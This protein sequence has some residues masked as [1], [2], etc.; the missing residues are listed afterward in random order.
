[1][2]GM[3]LPRGVIS[4][5]VVNNNIGTF[6][7]FFYASLHVSGNFSRGMYLPATVSF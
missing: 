3:N 2:G 4:P 7:R 1:M 6:C 5:A